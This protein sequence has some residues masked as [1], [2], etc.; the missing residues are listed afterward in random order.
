MDKYFNQ[1]N[2]S[3]RPVKAV[4]LSGSAFKDLIE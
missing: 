4:K 2:K 3:R 1:I